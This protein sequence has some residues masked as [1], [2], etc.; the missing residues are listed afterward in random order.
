[1][2]FQ[3]YR[4]SLLPSVVRVEQLDIVVDRAHPRVPLLL[5]LRQ[6]LHL[7]LR[8]AAAYRGAELEVERERVARQLEAARVD[9]PLAEES[10]RAESA[11]RPAPPRPAIAITLRVIIPF[12]AVVIIV[13]DMCV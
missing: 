11:R 4:L 3:L 10:P 8:A 1:M 9:R 5:R 6:Q 12:A 7:R 13:T 2:F